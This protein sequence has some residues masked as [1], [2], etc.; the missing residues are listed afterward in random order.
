[1]KLMH[2]TNE[3]PDLKIYNYQ[4]SLKYVNNMAK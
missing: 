3:Q 4:G 2:H 1:M